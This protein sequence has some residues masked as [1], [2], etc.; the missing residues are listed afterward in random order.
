MTFYAVCEKAVTILDMKNLYL[1]NE[2]ISHSNISHHKFGWKELFVCIHP[3]K[4]DFL[5]V[6]VY[7]DPMLHLTGSDL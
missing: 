4:V 1:S 6:S 7:A 2:T 3:N 5:Q